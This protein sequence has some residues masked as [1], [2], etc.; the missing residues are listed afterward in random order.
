MASSSRNNNNGL[1]GLFS[2]KGRYGSGKFTQLYLLT[3]L[4][5]LLVLSLF[6]I[7][8][9]EPVALSILAITLFVVGGIVQIF[10]V[11]KRLHD[12]ALSGWFLLVYLLIIAFIGFVEGLVSLG[13][14]WLVLLVRLLEVVF[15]I[16]FL[17]F[18][19]FKDG[20]QGPNAYGE[21]L[22]RNSDVNPYIFGTNQF[23]LGLLIV[24]LSIGLYQSIT[25][26]YEAIERQERLT[27][28]TR[29]RMANVR[30]AL[31]RYERTAG[32]FPP[33]LDSLVTWIKQDSATVARMDSIFGAGFDPDS[34]PFSP[35]TGARFEYAVND[36]A[37]VD[38]YLLE[39][40]DSEDYIGTLEEDV[41][42][43]NAA[44]WE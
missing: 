24:S 30:T 2:L 21:D 14:S 38:T 1:P 20:T 37:R 7:L 15:A 8:D 11:V 22:P 17:G 18:L 27:Q 35:R 34:L 41:T 3:I 23:L 16:G 33:T 28:M 19:M 36:T 44:S 9:E 26:P 42:Q 25:A 29:Q 10:L 31:T 5:G 43:V 32:T 12:V 40:P 13:D 6:F 4:P 39:D